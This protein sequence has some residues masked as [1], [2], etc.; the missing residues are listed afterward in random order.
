MPS[1]RRLCQAACAA[2]VD[3]DID[4]YKFPP[5]QR[6]P[7]RGGLRRCSIQRLPCEG[8]LARVARLR[9]CQPAVTASSDPLRQAFGLPPPLGHQGEAFLFSHPN[10]PVDKYRSPRSGSSTT[11]V[12][13]WNSGLLVS[14]TA[15]K[16]AAPPLGPVRIPSVLL[17]SLA[18]P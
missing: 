18:M 17:K 16:S 13:P 1:C 4:P 14:C 5:H 6:L 10:I 7:L 11:T 12:L 9:G 3:A 2:R 8:E 15:A